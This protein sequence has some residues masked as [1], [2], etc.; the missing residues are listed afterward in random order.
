MFTN[1]PLSNNS[2]KLYNKN[3]SYCIKNIPDNIGTEEKVKYMR[4]FIA[5]QL[6]KDK[7]V[8]DKLK[9]KVKIVVRS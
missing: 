8:G 1:T 6:Q 9:Q 3:K 4:D 7:M 2:N 5:Q